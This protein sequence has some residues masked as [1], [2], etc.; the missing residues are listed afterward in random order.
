LDLPE[1]SRDKG[2]KKPE[3]ATT[4]VK[5]PLL[6]FGPGGVGLPQLCHFWQKQ[7]TMKNR[8]NKGQNG[9]LSFRITR[10]RSGVVTLPRPLPETI[11]E[12]ERQVDDAMRAMV[13]SSRDYVPMPDFSM[14]SRAF[15]AKKPV[16]VLAMEL[17][18]EARRK[19]QEPVEAPS[20]APGP[21]DESQR[22]FF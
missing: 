9:L 15:Y 20:P 5:L 18:E 17:M 6:P 4:A 1:D 7:L 2:K 12:Y 10:V 11:A 8:L 13:T 3:A 14:V 21:A 22:S 16:H 19:T